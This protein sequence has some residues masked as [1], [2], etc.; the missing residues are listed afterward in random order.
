MITPY[1]KNLQIEELIPTNLTQDDL[2]LLK[3]LEEA[4][5]SLEQKK[6][7]EKLIEEEQRKLK[8]ERSL[9]FQKSLLDYV[10]TKLPKRVFETVTLK[11]TN[12]NNDF[13]PIYSNESSNNTTRHL[14]KSEAII[15][16]E[17]Q[18]E[19]ND[20]LFINYH[21]NCKSP[22]VQKNISIKEL[23]DLIK[24]GNGNIDKFNKARSYA[25]GSAEYN[26]IKRNQL[27]T[28]RYSFILDGYAKNENIKEATGLI[29]LDVDGVDSI[30]SSDLIFASWKSLSSTG[31]GILVK[32]DG[33]KLNNYIY[34]YQLIA[35]ELEVKADKGADAAIQQNVISYDPTIY[36]NNNSRIFIA[37]ENPSFVNGNNS[38]KKKNNKTP[39]SSTV[40]KVKYNHINDYKTPHSST[41]TID[42][43]I[44]NNIDSIKTP[45]SSTTSDFV[46]N[47]IN[48]FNKSEATDIRSEA[49][50]KK[51][52]QLETNEGFLKIRFNNINDYFQ[53]DNSNDKGYIVFE[54]EKEPMIIPFV[55]KTTTGA[56]SRTIFTYLNQIATLNKNINFKTLKSVADVENKNKCVPPLTEENIIT[57]V[58]DVLALLKEDSLYVS[59]NKERRIIF[60]PKLNIVRKEKQLIVNQEIGK[61]KSNKTK[62]EI[63]NLIENWDFTI[64]GKI[65]QKKVSEILNKSIAT[66]E[67]YWSEFKNYTNDLNS[68]FKP[69][70]TKAITNTR[71]SKKSQIKPC[72][73]DVEI[74]NPKKEAMKIKFDR[75]FKYCP[76]PLTK[77]TPGQFQTL[78]SYVFYHLPFKII[79]ENCCDITKNDFEE[80]WSNIQQLKSHL[81][82]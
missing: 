75:V 79:Y 64:N 56:R 21:N 3:L 45:H 24:Y 72:I 67:R 51:E 43:N 6:H 60:D 38:N 63:Y 36:I 8:K 40:G 66:I 71:K 57:I 65:T 20:G 78:T 54:N 76:N 44:I 61:L 37:K 58:N 23:F 33:L 52:E 70:K 69:Q 62:Q 50:I 73:E 22:T 32:I 59:F 18:L 55:E 35:N 42:N 39:H 12:I 17:K 2:E 46:Y 13:V 74:I 34:N 81:K 7:N 31:Y 15:K 26:K 19:T 41:V 11:P 68:D 16:K 29:Y 77:M 28:V 53:N 10:P 48:D 27:P 9:E 49:T 82:K 14:C 25:K 30:P 5:L 1:K 4:E 47:N 80:F